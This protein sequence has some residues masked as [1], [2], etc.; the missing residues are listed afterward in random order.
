M[1]AAANEGIF[2]LYG[3]SGLNAQ[4]EPDRL[5]AAFNQK[6]GL[7]LD[8]QY[9]QSGSMTRDTARMITEVARASPH[10]GPDGDDR[11]PLRHA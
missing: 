4:P 5:F 10:L 7:N 3:P 9:T 2:Q 1:A 8:Y 11:R 6:Y